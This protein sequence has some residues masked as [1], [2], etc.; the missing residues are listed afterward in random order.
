MTKNQLPKEAYPVTLNG[1]RDGVG[2][3]LGFS[4]VV[5][6]TAYTKSSHVGEYGWGGAAS[7]HFWISPTDDLAVV[8]LTQHMPFTF[9]LEDVVKPLVYEALLD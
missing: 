7:T 5:E 2:F 3:G 6:Q 8:V 4:V 9:L 1:T